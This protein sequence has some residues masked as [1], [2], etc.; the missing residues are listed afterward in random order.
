L[1]YQHSSA[2]S[3][4]RRSLA[5]IGGGAAGCFAAIIAAS[6]DPDLDITL[7]EKSNALLG[8]VKISGGGR[9]NVTQHCFDPEIL[10]KSYPRGS[11]ELLGLLHR[12]GPGNMMTWLENKGVSLKSEIDGRVFPSS[13]SSDTIIQC[14]KDQLNKFKITVKLNHNIHK[15]EKCVHDGWKV[16]SNTTAAIFDK[17]LLTTGGSTAVWV[18]LDKLG[19][20]II[21]PVP[22][23]FTFNIQDDR[24]A[25]LQG[26]SVQEAIISISGTK[27]ITKGALLITH[28]GI[29][30]PAVLAL[31]AWAARDLSAVNYQFSVIINFTGKPLGEVKTMLAQLKRDHAKKKVYSSGRSLEIPYRLWASLC[32]ASGIQ[33]NKNW[34][35]IS[36]RMIDALSAQLVEGTFQVTSKSTFKEE[37][38]TAGGVN[39]KE[40]NF[41]TM[42][43]KRFPGLY[44]AG[45]V[46]NIDALTGGYNFQAAWTTAWIAGHGISELT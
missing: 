6:T 10:V 26:I 2:S 20:N 43:S 24:L 45:E 3:G 37:F 33:E 41:K 39:L 22:S 23:L 27:H 35:D 25:G 42:E 34:G 32:V 5:I 11:R 29:S 18:M 36:T 31:S 28:K 12:F 19:L 40:V 1:E 21:D 17:I 14:F 7:F 9:C 8:K 30:G 16:D 13:D 15:L 38:V 4:K 46:L 44:F